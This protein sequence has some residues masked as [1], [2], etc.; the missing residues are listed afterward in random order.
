MFLI[1]IF[2]K[3]TLFCILCGICYRIY[4]SYYVYVSSLLENC[5]YKLLC[6]HFCATFPCIV[7]LKLNAIT[8]Q[9]TRDTSG[10]IYYIYFFIFLSNYFQL[11]SAENTS[12][13]RSLIFSKIRTLLL[14]ILVEI[15]I[16]IKCRYS[17][18]LYQKK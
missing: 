17:K 5:Q 11:S 3:T 15:I 18:Y 2:L 14:N 12:I 16:D 4:F 10:N 8:H 6:V 9:W 13:P 1:I 7:K